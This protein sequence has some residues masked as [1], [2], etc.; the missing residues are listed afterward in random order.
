[1][2]LRKFIETVVVG[3]GVAAL[4]PETLAQPVAIIRRVAIYRDGLI[5]EDRPFS[6]ILKDDILAIEGETP[7]IWYIATNDAFAHDEH[8]R[9]C[10]AVIADQPTA[11]QIADAQQQ[12]DNLQEV[13]KFL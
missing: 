8:G 7:K 5:H 12:Y 11:Q 10:Y 3:A 6:D 13:K 2:K 9:D 1:M 4:V